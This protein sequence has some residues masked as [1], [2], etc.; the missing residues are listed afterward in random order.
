MQNNIQDIRI[1]DM[2]VYQ[3]IQE[4]DGRINKT[5]IHLCLGSEMI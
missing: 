5:V 1:L 4:L 2:K 3:M